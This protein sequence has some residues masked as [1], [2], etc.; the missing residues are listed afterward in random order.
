MIV[1][2]NL[3]GE[4]FALNAELI[5]RVEGNAETHVTLVT[6]TAYVVQESEEE[7]IRLHRLDRAEVQVLAGRVIV[8]APLLAEGGGGQSPLRLLEPRRDEGHESP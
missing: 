6:G 5:E 4:E 7:V 8:A 3:H 1:L 2:H